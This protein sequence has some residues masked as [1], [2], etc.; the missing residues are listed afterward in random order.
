MT[1]HPPPYWSRPRILRSQE[2]LEMRLKEFQCTCESLTLGAICHGVL[3]ISPCPGRGS[4]RGSFDLKSSTL[5]R[6]YKSPLVPQGRTSVWYTWP[7]P[8]DILPLHIDDVKGRPCGSV[9]QLATCS[10]GK[11]EALGSSPG[12]ATIFFLPCDIWW[13]S[14]G[15]RLRQRASKSACLVVLP[16]FRADSGT[17]LI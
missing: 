9:A 15:S 6:R 12:R 17:N 1:P 10:H 2:S 3:K 4:N 11:Q 5:P 8:C 7:I 16:L 13:P 14:V